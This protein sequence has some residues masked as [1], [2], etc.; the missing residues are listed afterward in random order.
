VRTL[1]RILPVAADLRPA[2]YKQLLAAAYDQMVAGT[3]SEQDR[4]SVDERP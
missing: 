2:V 4:E 3:R 1:R